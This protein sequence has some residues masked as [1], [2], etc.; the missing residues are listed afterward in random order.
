MNGMTTT[1]ETSICVLICF[2]A[3]FFISAVRRQVQEM[4]RKNVNKRF[5]SHLKSQKLFSQKQRF[6][7][8]LFFVVVDNFNLVKEI[9]KDWWKLIKNRCKLIVILDL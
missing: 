1:S 3:S 5:V 8:Y 9:S 2:I 6:Q 4:K 7:N